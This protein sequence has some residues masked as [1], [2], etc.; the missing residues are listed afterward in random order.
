MKTKKEVLM[1]II[2]LTTDMGYKDHYVAALK[3][4]LFSLAPDVK[5]I[6]ISH[7]VKPFNISQAA[8]FIESSIKNFPEGTIH[9]IGVDPEPLVNFSQ[10]EKSALPIIMKFKEQYFVGTDNGI[11]SLL[12]RNAVPQGL[13][14]IDD[15]L[16][17]PE[18][19]KFPTKN[20]LV[21]AACKLANGEL[22]SSFASETEGYR[23]AFRINPVI[24]GHTLKGSVIHIDH[25]GNLITNI[26]Q[27][28]FYRL[29]RNIPFIIYFRQKEYFIDEIS[30]GYNEVSPGEKVAIF[31]D[32]G[33]LEIAINKGTPENGGGANMLFGLH[34]GDVVRIEFLPRGSRETLASLF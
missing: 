18:L 1:R 21:P 3:G 13:W 9:V 29:G 17:Q 23:K 26:R 31:N 6:D 15:V 11:F 14:A 2:T 8:Y 27:D 16:S 33:L 25:Y 30:L 12:L 4:R 7:S 19:M 5:V 34:I 24:D 20:I 32:E 22:P 28:D 10:P